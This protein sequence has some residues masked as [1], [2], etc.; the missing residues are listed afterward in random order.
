MQI[1]DSHSD[2][3]VLVE[4]GRRIAHQRLMRNISQEELAERA[5]VARITVARIEAGQP[6]NI[7]SFLRILRELELLEAL[8]QLLPEPGPSPIQLLALERSR[9][10]R[11]SGRRQRRS[12]APSTAWTWG[13]G[14]NAA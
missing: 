1:Q 12:A 14:D 9:R 10:R 7:V 8:G 4:L 5:G 6:T 3:A 2:E 11:A 13:D